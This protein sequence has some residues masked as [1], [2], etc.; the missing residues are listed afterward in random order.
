MRLSTCFREEARSTL[1][2][3]DES[4]VL[5][6]MVTHPRSMLAQVERAMRARKRRAEGVGL[7]MATWS[8][9]LL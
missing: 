7:L 6:Y 8:G 9:L 5:A 3:S 2:R 4:P 1:N